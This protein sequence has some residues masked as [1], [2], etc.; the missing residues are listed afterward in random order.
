MKSYERLLGYHYIRRI[1]E[2]AKLFDGK[3]PIFDLN[4]GIIEK[5]NE[6]INS[7]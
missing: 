5:D 3:S 7:I 6:K 1:R 4:T 2:L